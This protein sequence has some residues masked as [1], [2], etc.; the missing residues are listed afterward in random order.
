[1]KMVNVTIRLDEDLKN[2]AEALFRE[3]GFSF[4]AAVHT[5]LR[6]AVREQRIPFE[7][8]KNPSLPYYEVPKEIEEAL[9]KWADEEL[10]RYD[11]EHRSE[12]PNGIIPTPDKESD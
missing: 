3:L 5:F 9:L 10:R 7:I 2:Q 4:S 8:S 11:E 1:M 6:Q 12:Y